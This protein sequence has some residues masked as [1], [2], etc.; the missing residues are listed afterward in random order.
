MREFL[1][2]GAR[3]LLH[4]LAEGGAR[5]SDRQ[6]IEVLRE[7]PLGRVA[8]DH[9]DSGFGQAGADIG[10]R[11]GGPQVGRRGFPNGSLPVHSLEEPFVILPVAGQ[12]TVRVEGRAIVEDL[13][14]R[15]GLHGEVTAERPAEIFGADLGGEIARL[16]HGAHVNLR[17][18]PEIAVE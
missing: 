5:E 11:R 7:R 1:L 17:M 14:E 8:Q 10:R 13:G 15:Q 2:P 3:A 4:V 6:L 16:F 18:L 9:D 12:P